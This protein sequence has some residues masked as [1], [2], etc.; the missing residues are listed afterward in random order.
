MNTASLYSRLRAEMS[1]PV[2]RGTIASLGIRLGS[3]GVGVV[4][5]VVTAR[6]LGPEGYGAIAFAMSFAVLGATISMLGQEYLVIRELPRLASVGDGQAVDKFLARSGGAV[7]LAA[8]AM[9]ALAF[10]W[11]PHAARGT[12]EFDATLAFVPILIPLFA[13][14]FLLR[15]I[16]RGVGRV[17]LAQ[18]PFEFARPALLMLA[19]VAVVV[20]GAGASTALYMGMA[21]VISALCL[22]V[23]AVSVWRALGPLRAARRGTAELPRMVGPGLSLLGV[24]ILAHLLGEMNTLLLG[25]LATPEE[26]GLFQPVARVAPLLLIASQAVT[27]RY[28]P[29]VSELWAA[30][31]RAM[32]LRITK[33]ATLVTFASAAALGAGLAVAAP[34]ILL[35]FGEDFLVMVPALWWVAGAQ[36]FAAACGL[37]AVLLTMTGPPRRMIPAQIAGLAVNLALA[38]WLIP[39][40]GAMG[41]A[42][43]MAGGIV[44]LAVAS[45]SITR[46]FLGIDPSLA[47]VLLRGRREAG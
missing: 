29:R 18:V 42:Q 46:R 37:C 30:G 22:A 1:G 16:G 10:L 31:D 35:L 44:G 9:G 47:G 40:S 21:T 20:T 33:R 5:A 8:A 12:P 17:V 38:L 4:L 19:L 2:A 13:M 36:V 3:I 15:G 45:L 26:T 11:I 34:W 41:A 14:L 6:V 39:V 7:V 24:G 25:W 23:A 32:L 28:A 43:A 27:M